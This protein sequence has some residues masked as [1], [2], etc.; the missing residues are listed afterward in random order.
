MDTTLRQTVWDWTKTILAAVIL[1]LLLRIFVVE[2]RWIPSESMLP[3]FLVGDRLLIEKITVKTGGFQYGD[4]VVFDPPA[5]S[6]MREP[7]IKRIIGLPGD[8]ILIRTG[9]VYV[10]GQPRQEAYI[11][12]KEQQNF[13]PYTVPEQSL[14]VMGDNGNNSY[15]SRFWGS[16]PQTL[17]IG[18]A[19][20]KFYPVSQIGLIN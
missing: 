8:V 1:S 2:A 10:N 9:V 15:D 18:K 20:L 17:I 6:G 12:E 16:V 13:G 7:L 3:T 19:F 14:F 11:L 5:A 4:I